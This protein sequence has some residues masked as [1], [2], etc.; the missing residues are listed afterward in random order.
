MTHDAVRVRRVYYP[1]HQGS[2]EDDKFFK[3]RERHTKGLGW[4]GL[5]WPGVFDLSETFLSE[6]L[7]RA[8][9]RQGSENLKVA[10]AR[11]VRYMKN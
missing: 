6:A 7:P 1:V 11:R 9:F 4:L 10:E 8:R 3:P 2:I 5:Y